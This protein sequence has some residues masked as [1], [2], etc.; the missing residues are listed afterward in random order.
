MKIERRPLAGVTLGSILAL[1]LAACGGSSGS[2]GS[3][4]GSS[5]SGESDPITWMTML[6]TPTTPSET[7]PIHEALV[8]TT[9]EQFEMQWVPDASKEEKLN[10]ALASNTLADITSLT[11]VDRSTTIR[12]ALSSGMF[13]DVEEYLDQ[14]P[15]LSKID[16]KTI[17]VAKVD[18]R[19]YGIPFQKPIARYGV[20]VRQDWLDNLGLE[21]PHTLDELANV[22]R[23]FTEDDP[24]GNGVDDTVGFID[25]A[26][27]YSL[28]FRILAG[29]FGAGDKF[30]VAENNEIV[31][32]FQG[33]SWM[34]A[35][36]WYREVYANGWV[37]QE[38]VTMQKQN[39][40]D[41]IAQSKGGIV[42][43]GLMEPRN[44]MSLAT[45]ADPETPM[46]WALVNDMTYADVPRRIVSD[47]GGGMGGL[48][49]IS[50]SSVS[51]EDE[52]LRVLGFIDSLLSEEAYTLMTYGI[53]G[54]HYEIDSE[55]IVS[56]IDQ[57]TWEQQV[58]PYASSRPSDLVVTFRSSEPYV[59]LGNELIA[60]NAEFA[61]TNPAQPLSSEAYDEGWSVID[62]TMMDAYN[63]FILG[64]I[65][66]DGYE[67]AIEDANSQGLTAVIEEFTADYAAVN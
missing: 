10:A 62:Q 46:S 25:R 55:G 30:E 63:K 53:E 58:Q 34:A 66:M 42:I 23:A 57:A 16:P 31:P 44:Y 60:E 52:L 50:K 22:A 49:A 54:E 6:H 12:N 2:A 61:V 4:E 19:L 18:G 56:I 45:N 41:A 40:Q 48:L 13:W 35:M 64:Q 65:D 26:E 11:Q 9:G 7:G 8:S 29:Y 1:T 3:S 5:E 47:T 15:N 36:E 32:A 39:Q 14:F 38:F 21:V 20:I 51:D 17:G 43:T 28:S 59:D 24:D 37:N 67:Q 33:E 27:S